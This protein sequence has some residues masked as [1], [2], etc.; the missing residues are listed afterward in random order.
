MKKFVIT[1]LFAAG[2]TLA[3]Y[4]CN[5]GAYDAEPGGGSPL[6]PLNPAESGVTVYLGTMKASVN[7]TRTLFYPA[8]YTEDDQGVKSLIAF[9]ENDPDF[10]HTLRFTITDMKS[11]KEFKYGGTYTHLDTSKHS[12]DSTITYGVKQGV[13]SLGFTLNGNEEG[14]LRGRFF[15]TMYKLLPK[16]NLKDS[17]VFADGEFYVPKKPK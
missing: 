15:G 3:L 7:G 11:I 9:R 13:G 8:Y 1:A 10:R 12:V 5:N 16:E 2:A 6:N 14:N 4:S 17:V